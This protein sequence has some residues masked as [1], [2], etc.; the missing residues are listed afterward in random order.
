MRSMESDRLWPRTKGITQKEQRLSHPSWTL[1]L[2]RVRSF[3]ASNT[4]AASSSVWAKMSETK[5]CCVV[6]GGE[7]RAKSTSGTNAAPEGEM[8]VSAQAEDASVISA[9]R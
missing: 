1:R 7:A 5:I 3:A 4:G 2:G 8:P 6:D 9:N